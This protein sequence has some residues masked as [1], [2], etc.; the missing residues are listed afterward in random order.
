MVSECLGHLEIFTRVVVSIC[1]R[2]KLSTLKRP[3]FISGLFFKF[4]SFKSLC[5]SLFSNKISKRNKSLQMTIKKVL[6]KDRPRIWWVLK[7]GKFNLKITE[8]ILSNF[9]E[10]NELKKTFYLMKRLYKRF[11]NRWQYNARA[12]AKSNGQNNLSHS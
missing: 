8:W 10:W 5:Q 1:R 2:D 9:R 7:Y 3:F 4:Y 12:L 6:S 11:M